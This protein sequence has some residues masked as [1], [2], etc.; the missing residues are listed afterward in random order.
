VETI[1]RIIANIAVV[2]TIHLLEKKLAKDDFEKL[3]LKAL[4]AALIAATNAF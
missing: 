4:Q 2:A 1:Y 3:A